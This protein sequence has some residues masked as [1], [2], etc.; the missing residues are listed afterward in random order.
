MGTFYCVLGGVTVLIALITVIFAYLQVA[1]SSQKMVSLMGFCA[2]FL[3]LGN[4]VAVVGS[5]TEVCVMGYILEHVGGVNIC[6]FFYYFLG[7]V[8]REEIPVKGRAFLFIWNIIILFFM[9]VGIPR[10]WFTNSLYYECEGIGNI[11]YIDFKK[12]YLLYAGLLVLY[13]VLTIVKLVKVWR[14][15]IYVLELNKKALLLFGLASTISYASFFINVIFETHYDYTVTG[16]T[17]GITIIAFVAYRCGV[18]PVTQSAQDVILDDLDDILIFYDLAGNLLYA[19]EKADEIYRADTQENYSLLYGMKVHTLGKTIAAILK[20]ANEQTYVLNDKT[21][22]CTIKDIYDK[23]NKLCGYV[24]W[25]RDITKETLLLDEA[26]KFR[27]VAEKANRAKSKF[28]AHMSHEIRTPINAVIGLDEIILRKSNEKQIVEIALDI[29]RAGKTLLAIINDVL[30]YSKIEAGKMEIVPADYEIS[31]MI[32][33]FKLM[34][35]LRAKRK[36]IGFEVKV[37]DDIPKV[38]HGDELRIRQIITNLLTNS[39]KYTQK[40]KVTLHITCEKKTE[41]SLMLKAVIQDT[42]IGIKKADMQ[43]LFG[44]FERVENSFNHMTEGT[45]LGLSIAKQLIDLMRGRLE[46]ES[47]Y[48]KGSRFTVIIP[49]TYVPDMLNTE[50]AG[51]SDAKPAR[52]PEEETKK[53]RILKSPGTRMLIVDDN[54]INRFV[55]KMLLNESGI[56]FAECVNGLECLEITKEEH[57]DLIILDLMM[58]EMD[59]LETIA[60]LQKDRTHKCQNV[61]II[62]LTADVQNGA[63][64]YYRSLGFADYITKPLDPKSYEETVG[65]VLTE[66]GVNVYY[67]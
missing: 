26:V 38:L 20:T 44:S 63:R 61:P 24:H 27:E 34:I 33:D 67:E 2:F 14:T 58:P 50:T 28:L 35:G 3:A 6:L 31:N 56:E 47:E 51:A 57:F 11:R 5:T 13:L 12:T 21:Y 54:E 59:G 43:R 23:H 52:K 48:G 65:R 36:G 53:R 18:Y 8:L 4:F 10:G 64:E 9:I 17:I 29:Q 25:L 15:R 46:A 66:S 30:D 41:C 62:L 40:G 45:G 22:K 49:Q 32:E 42:G 60:N 19:N 55:S 37:A 39:V 7:I 16:C 1:S